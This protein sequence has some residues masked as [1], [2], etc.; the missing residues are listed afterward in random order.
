MEMKREGLGKGGHTH[1]ERLPPPPL[2]SVSL[3]P[4]ASSRGCGRGSRKPPPG[5]ALPASRPALKTQNHPSLRQKG[6]LNPPRQ[7][8]DPTG[9]APTPQSLPDPTGVASARP[10]PHGAR[11]GNFPGP[12]PPPP[13]FYTP[14]PLILPLR[15]CTKPP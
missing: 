5:P 7:L 8:P 3:P 2:L 13:R 15:F 9:L 1:N 10:C 11:G 12:A 4:S 6:A 14:H